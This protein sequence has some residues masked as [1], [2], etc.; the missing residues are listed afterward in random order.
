[1]HFACVCQW[2]S[3]SIYSKAFE[4]NNHVLSQCYSISYGARTSHVRAMIEKHLSVDDDVVKRKA[5]YRVA[6]HHW[7]EQL[8]LRNK[9]EKRSISKLISREEAG[10]YGNQFVESS[11]LPN[12]DTL[13][14]SSQMHVQAP[15]VSE[16][17]VSTLVASFYRT[18]KKPAAVDCG[19]SFSFP[20]D[21]ETAPMLLP[22]ML[23]SKS[24]AKQAFD[25]SVPFFPT[26]Y[27]NRSPSIQMNS[28]KML[29]PASENDDCCVAAPAE[30]PSS[31]FFKSNLDH[32]PTLTNL[33]RLIVV[34]PCC[35][36]I[37]QNYSHQ[38]SQLP[39]IHLPL[40][41]APIPSP[42]H[43]LTFSFPWTPTL[44]SPALHR[45][46]VVLPSHLHHYIMP[47]RI[48][49]QGCT[50]RTLLSETRNDSYIV[51]SFYK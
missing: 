14:D 31:V 43:L 22:M 1:M 3:C 47:N 27:F 20:V 19:V 8:I 9:N 41:Y 21:V 6:Y 42:I 40:N 28:S 36:W 34:F 46:I 50:Y 30:P 16:I 32:P 23:P 12:D 26:E 48:L 44:N 33:H 25:C 11:E 5:V 49:I 38:P 13:D 15:T 4:E 39:M 51:I 29:Q 10:N 45:L 7:P 18:P 37:Q 35:D 24:T 2:Q 17:E